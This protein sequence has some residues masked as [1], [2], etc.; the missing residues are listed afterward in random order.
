M[1]AVLLQTRVL[2][3]TLPAFLHEPKLVLSCLGSPPQLGV[4]H[5]VTLQTRCVLVFT[6]PQRM[7]LGLE[8][9]HPTSSVCTSVRTILLFYAFPFRFCSHCLVYMLHP[10][11]RTPHG[12]RHYINCT[13]LGLRPRGGLLACL[14]AL[15]ISSYLSP[16]SIYRSQLFDLASSIKAEA[17]A[18]LHE[19]QNGPSS[20]EM[21]LYSQA[22]LLYKQAL[23]VWGRGVGRVC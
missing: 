18:A 15:T 16:I 8:S 5:E 19:A 2:S 22:E 1:L 10:F 23:Q 3:L 11:T 12:I 20:T 14:L 9:S 4:E 13:L 6:S 17:Q 21:R 7:A